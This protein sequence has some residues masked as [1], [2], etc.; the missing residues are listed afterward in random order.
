M[1]GSNKIRALSSGLV[2]AALTAAPVEAQQTKSIRLVLDWAFQGQQGIFT[3]PVSDG[4]FA[5]YHLNV[6]VDRGV[7]SGDT[8]SKVASGATISARPISIPWSASWARI[9]AARSS[10]CSW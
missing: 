6:T 3:V 4:T 9:R 2:I 7:G 8:V 10:P 1:L 5:R